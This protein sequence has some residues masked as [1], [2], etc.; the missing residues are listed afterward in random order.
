MDKNFFG[1]QL[2]R[3][4]STYS[5]GAMNEERAQLLWDRFKGVPNRVFENAVNF[6]ISEYTSQNLPAMSKFAEAVGMFRTN[7]SAQMQELLPAFE[8]EACRDFG[9]GFVGDT[10]TACTCS[11]GKKI[12]PSELARQ[13]GFYEKGKRL[14]MDPKRFSNIGT[15]L[16][17][18]QRERF[19][20]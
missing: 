10:V 20:A 2:A 4:R 18:D 14:F 15:S 7:V 8:C 12:G 16:P 9:F 19:E 5:P 6:L 17:Y 11:L 1:D 3:L 13:Q